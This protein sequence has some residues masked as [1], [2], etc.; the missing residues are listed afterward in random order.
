MNRLTRLRIW[1]HWL[2]LGMLAA[3]G[4]SG[5]GFVGESLSDG[6][7]NLNTQWSPRPAGLSFALARMSLR[8][9]MNTSIA[10]HW[11]DGE[12]RDSPA[13]KRSINPATYET[14]GE[15]ADGGVEEA[16][17]AIAAAQRAFRE[18]AWPTDRA[19]RS[20]VLNELADAFERHTEE[21]VDL[22]SMENG[23]V[24]PEAYFEVSKVPSK[25]RYYA[26]LALTEH[27]RAVEPIPGALS[28]VLRQ[29]M[30]VAGIIAPVE[31]AR[32]PDD[33]VT[34]ARL[35]CGHDCR[36][37]D[38]RTNGTDQCTGRKDHEPGTFVAPRSDQ[39]VLRVRCRGCKAPGRIAG[40]A[41]HQFHGQ[42]GDRSRHL[43]GG[44]RS[45]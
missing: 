2:Q 6:S 14:I 24:R 44:C 40:R 39:P 36:D 28:V 45:T 7:D 26:S 5:Y 43:R 25:L 35:G 42:H 8:I 30:G 21:L 27:G 18:S 10:L 13:R 4:Y 32:D 22:L 1:A 20:K 9:T 31:L 41:G 23:K 15:Y 16:T 38:A 33:P 11:I 17:L 3:A 34:G 29:P 12:W 37:Q 19:L